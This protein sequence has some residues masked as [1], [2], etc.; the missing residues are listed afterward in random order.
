MVANSFVVWEKGEEEGTEKGRFILNFKEHSKHWQK[1]SIKMENL[2]SFSLQLQPG[3]SMVSFDIKSGYR[4]FRLAPAMRRWFL[5]HYQGRYY[6][7]IALPFGWGRSPMWFT[8]LLRPL[9]RYLRSVLRYRV[10]PYLDDFLVVPSP[11]GRRARKTDCRTATRT[12]DGLLKRLGLTRH[13]RK[14]EW[15]TGGSTRVEH[16]GAIVDTDAMQFYASPRKVNKIRQL[17]GALLKQSAAGRRW[18]SKE[19]VRS[20]VGV[21][22]SLLL[23]MQFARFFCRSLYDDLS[24]RRHP[25]PPPRAA[26]G[27]QRIRLGHASLKDLRTWRTLTAGPDQATHPGRAIL[28]LM[29][30]GILHTDASDLGYGGTLGLRGEAGDPG[31]CEAQALWSAPERGDCI[32]VRELRAV[33]KLLDG[34]LGERS[35]AAGMTLIRAL[36]DNTSVAHALRSFSSAST[37]MMRELRKLKRVL[38]RRGL[39]I[40]SEWLPSAANRFADRLSRIFSVG[41]IGTRKELV[42]SVVDGLELPREVLPYAGTLGEH[43]VYAR[44]HSLDELRRPWHRNEIQVLYPPPDLASATVRKLRLTGAPAVLL[45]PDWGGQAWAQE[46]ES[47]CRP[48]ETFRRA[49]M[50]TKAFQGHRTVNPAWQ[51]RVFLANW[52]ADPLL[53]PRT[54]ADLPSQQ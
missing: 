41:D 20:F 47:L 37:G 19:K 51:V 49:E 40:R 28:P 2:S 12:I 4:H 29:P 16:L 27:G 31:E 53:T 26:R 24:P 25:S 15:S 30:T 3:D 33:R 34:E 8:Q 22:V 44:R 50:G 5:F 1:G 21:A 38:D 46:A 9:V 54:S 39:Q 10:L 32:T 14:G 6:Q 48:G 42:Q 13:P 11:I 7:A 36:V 52:P 45:L 35:Q 23:A 18:V 17:A 43:P